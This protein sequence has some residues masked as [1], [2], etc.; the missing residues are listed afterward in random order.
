MT[1][2]G[3]TRRRRSISDPAR[4]PQA[5]PQ[6]QA[7]LLSGVRHRP[8]AGGH[9]VSRR[10]RTP[11]TFLTET[12]PRRLVSGFLTNGAP[13]VPGAPY[14]EPC[15]DDE[16]DVFNGSGR[17]LRRQ[18]HQL[19]LFRSHQ[20]RD[21]SARVQGRQHPDRRGLQQG[22]LPLPAAAHHQPV[23]GRGGLSRPAPS[24]PSPLS[25]A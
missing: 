7:G 15:I 16:G 21:E 8:G 2:R 14:Q 23:G 13:P 5:A 19:Y 1:G 24:R 10:G 9:G 12:G 22:G 20:D 25:S 4:L 17:V 6:G 18:R 11:R 3:D